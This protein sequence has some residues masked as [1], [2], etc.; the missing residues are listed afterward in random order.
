VISSDACGDV[1]L[2]LQPACIPQCYLNW[3]N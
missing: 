2:R 1:T 3:N